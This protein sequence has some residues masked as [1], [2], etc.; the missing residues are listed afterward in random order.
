MEKTRWYKFYSEIFEEDVFK[1]LLDS[2]DKPLRVSL[3]VNIKKIS[4]ENFK[5]L[6]KKRNWDL[7]PVEWCDEGFFVKVENSEFRLSKDLYYHAGYFYL[8]EASSMFPVTL[9]DKDEYGGKVWLDMAASPGSKTTQ[10]ENLTTYRSIVIANDP[11][12]S[13]LRGLSYNLK[14][15]GATNVVIIAKDGRFF[16]NDHPNTFDK[17]LLDAPCSGDGMAKKK[18]KILKSWSPNY[19]Q[20][21][22]KLQKQL[23]LSAFLALKPGGEMIYSTCTFSPYENENV[24]EYLLHH[25]GDIIETQVIEG[26]SGTTLREFDG[27]KYHEKV[28]AGIRILPFKHNTE[29]FFAIKIIKT[30]STPKPKNKVNVLRKTISYLPLKK[31]RIFVSYLRKHFGIQF[32]VEKRHSLVQEEKEIYMIPKRYISEFSDMKI[33][34]V[35]I[36]LGEMHDHKVKISH[37]F[38]LKYGD[39][40]KKHVYDVC[41]EDYQKITSAQNIIVTKEW[42]TGEIIILKKSG[43]VI[44]MGKY[45]DGFIKNLLPRRSIVVRR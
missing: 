24:V 3:R 13:R 31:E 26:Y 34:S 25:Y 27:R 4:I 14:L 41:D 42:K 23:I 32:D 20:F 9:F 17:I 11:A 37:C 18:S 28:K 15:W 35:G 30:D 19:S 38:V 5:N 6:A 33:H 43:V 22:A 36:K 29:G 1:K 45:M 40:A 12:R 8:Q 21:M 44:G 16:G 10:L 39:E 7:S 2:M